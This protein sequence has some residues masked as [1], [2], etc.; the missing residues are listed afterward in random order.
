MLIFQCENHLWVFCVRLKIEAQSLHLPHWPWGKAHRCLRLF[1]LQYQTLWRH[2]I[3][4][5]SQYY[6][7]VR[8]PFHQT[9]SWQY[10]SGKMPTCTWERRRN[11]IWL[12]KQSMWLIQKNG[13]LLQGPRLLKS[14]RFT[15]YWLVLLILLIPFFV[16]MYYFLYFLFYYDYLVSSYFFV[17]LKKY[18]RVMTLCFETN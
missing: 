5:S 13:Q 4:L 15:E 17:R 14:P 6:W 7:W 11:V 16:F 9:G 18:F 8:S 2:Q 10:D 12:F 3:C 1:A